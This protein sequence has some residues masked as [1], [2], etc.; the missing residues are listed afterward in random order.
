MDNI[1]K[2]LAELVAIHYAHATDQACNQAA[3]DAARAALAEQPTPTE[4]HNPWRVSLENCISGDNYLRA[5]EY[6]DLIEELDDLYRLRTAL[7]EQPSVL[8][9]LTDEQIKEQLPKAV[10]LPPGW[11]DFARAIEAMHG[12]GVKEEA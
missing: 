4:F 12:I 10:R 9:P 8:V 6:R 11:L 7:A 3:W 5:R 2:A 1:R